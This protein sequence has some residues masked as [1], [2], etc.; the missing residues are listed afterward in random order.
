MGS[1]APE[2]VN[3]LLDSVAPDQMLTLVVAFI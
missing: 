1:D 2:A 3:K